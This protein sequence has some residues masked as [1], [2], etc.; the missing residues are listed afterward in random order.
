MNTDVPLPMNNRTRLGLGVLEAAVLLGLL[1][2]ALL[3]VTPWGVNIL[4]W[5]AALGVAVWT[6]PLCWGGAAAAREKNR[7]MPLMLFFAAALRG[8]TRRRSDS[9]TGWA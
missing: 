7:L 5:A 3:R 9:W 1:G 8:A 6:V 2:D 4:L